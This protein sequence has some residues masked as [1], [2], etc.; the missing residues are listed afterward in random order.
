MMLDAHLQQAGLIVLADTFDSGWKLE[1]D[2]HAAPILRANLM[3]RAAL[4]PAGSHSLVYTYQPLMLKLG[5]LSSAAGLTILL[6]LYL[7]SRSRR[8]EQVI[9]EAGSMP[10]SH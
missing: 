4:V 6:G 10:D 2:G 5:A 3:M 7:W 1:I 8:L 9:L